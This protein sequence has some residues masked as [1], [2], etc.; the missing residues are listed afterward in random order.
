MSIE[1]PSLYLLANKLVEKGVSLDIEK[2]K[3]T[4]DLVMQVKA[5][6]ASRGDKHE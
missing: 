5:W 3:T 4:E 1:I 6:K 2:I